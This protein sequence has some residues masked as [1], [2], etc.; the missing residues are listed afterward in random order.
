[1][2]LR[3]DAAAHAQRDCS[4]N[5]PGSVSNRISKYA[6][7]KVELRLRGAYASG[8]N[9]PFVSYYNVGVN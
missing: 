2:S 6:S 1:M 3:S 7:H 8:I 4:G 5:T 9:G